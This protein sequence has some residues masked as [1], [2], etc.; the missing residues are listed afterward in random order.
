MLDGLP[1]A[2]EGWQ[3]DGVHHRRGNVR[4]ILFHTVQN[5]SLMHPYE[6]HQQVTY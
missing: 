3:F 1:I 4:G 5:V 2:E 6:S